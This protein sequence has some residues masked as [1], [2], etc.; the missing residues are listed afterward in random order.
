MDES[1]KCESEKYSESLS[2]DYGV[3]GVNQRSSA[4]SETGP[5]TCTLILERLVIGLVI[6]YLCIN[7]T[8]LRCKQFVSRQL[9]TRPITKMLKPS[10]RA[11]RESESERG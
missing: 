8:S 9:T 1:S 2:R 11:E 4:K 3:S 5:R 6:T 7:C 10:A